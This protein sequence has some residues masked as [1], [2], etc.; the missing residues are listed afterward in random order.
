MSQ[1]LCSTEQSAQYARHVVFEVD[2]DQK[3]IRTMIDSGATGN[4]MSPRALRKLGKQT[5]TKEKPYELRLAD[6]TLTDQGMV[7]QETPELEM[8]IQGHD[9][10]IVFDVVDIRYE[11]ILGIPW[12][13]KHN[14]RINWRQRRMEFPNCE[15]GYSRERVPFTTAVWVRPKEGTLAVTDQCPPEY[16]EFEE[17]F[18]DEKTSLALPKHQPWDHEIPLEPGTKPTF[19]PIY[20][21]SARELE[22]LREYLDEHLKKGFIRPSESP[23]GYPVLFA[24]KAG[25]GLRLCVDYRQ[26]NSITIK[27]RYPLPLIAEL[28]DKIQGA[29]IFTTIDLR[30]AYNLIRMKEGEE[31]KTAFRTRYG[32]Y[33]YLVMPF[34]LTNAPASCQ[35]LVN[36]ALR[37]YLDRFAVAYLDDILVY[38]RTV[39]EHTQHVKLVLRALQKYSLKVKLE[40]CEFHKKR[41]KFLGSILSTSGIEMDESKVAAIKEW[42]VPKSVKELQSFLGFANFYRRFIERYSKITTPMTVLTRKDVVFQWNREAN[43][44]F[45]ELKKKFTQAPILQT[46]DPERQIVLETDASDYAIGMCISQY[47]EEGRLKPVAFH[48]R[49]LQPAEQHYEIH[50]KELLAIVAAF[51]EWRVYLE[52]TKYPVKVFTDH[53]NLLYFTT[54]KDLNRRQVRWSELLSTFNFVI[55]YTRGRDNAKAD[56]LSRRPDHEEKG[57]KY[58]NAILRKEEH[59]IVYDHQTIASTHQESK[60]LAKEIRE[61]YEVDPMIRLIRERPGKYQEFRENA[62]GLVTFKGLIFV[63]TIMEKRV[64]E[65]HHGD[66]TK[67]HL[68]IE[69]TEERIAR[70]YYF[71]GMNRKIREWIKK[72]DLCW[73]TKNSRHKPYGEMKTPAAPTQAWTSIAWDFITKLPV[74][75]DPVTKFEYDAILVVTD[76]LS[77]YAYFI[78]FKETMTAEDLA[79]IFL[80]EIWSQHGMPQEIFSDRDKLFTSRFWRTFTA[81]LGSRQKM[82]TAFHPQ[83]DGQTE[84]INGILEQYLRCYVNYEQNDWCEL[85]P[86]AQFSYNDS[87][88]AT[89]ETPF[90]TNKG[91]HPVPFRTTIESKN[92][93]EGAMVRTNKLVDLQKQLS[94]DIEFLSLR[95]RKY[96]DRKRSE[97]PDFRKG[98]PVYLIRRNVKTK[99][100]SAK[101]DF[102]KLGPYEIEEV[103]GKTNYRLKLPKSMRIHPVFHI[104]LLEPAPKEAGTTQVEVEPDEEYE[105][106]KVL[107]HRKTASGQ[108]EY[109]IRW[110]GYDNSED[111][112]EPETN[113]SPGTLKAYEREV[114]RQGRKRVVGR[115]EKVRKEKKGEEI[116]G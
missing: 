57:R 55:S 92:Q 106:E 32:L 16:Q 61:A 30:A 94:L 51:S 67:G 74:S 33:E 104:S 22:V 19:R 2:I 115:Q 89:G 81:M 72:C 26:L 76:R 71:P 114:G 4:Y 11:A 91:Y 52:G 6:G 53:K 63:P 1:E 28:Q 65:E 75:R 5:R 31:W 42:P 44:A 79:Y 9:E 23:A 108:T 3:R 10:R 36:Q 48:S 35:A 18:K 82:S 97:G 49:K 111:S 83:T 96:Y 12:L 68:G 73:K 56:A 37:E 113:L 21:L 47:D 88:A 105:V 59:G 66:L 45:E 38:S 27:N 86:T 46:F 95:A 107:R 69:K 77:K 78:P 84:R 70:N 116:R 29:Q 7:K 98:D 24:P 20:Q 15:C 25:G 109:L 93:A 112:W 41:V 14:P 58:A 87:V 17:L 85:L 60:D 110:L 99:R 90:M 54:T 50:D 8:K 102:T 40:K 64:I 101:L 43:D 13:E 39:E 34:G 103:L 100:P 62:E 80:T